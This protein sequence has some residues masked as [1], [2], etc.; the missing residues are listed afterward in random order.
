MTRPEQEAGNMSKRRLLT[1]AVW[2]SAA[3]LAAAGASSA[4][5]KS[6]G[7]KSAGG[8]AGETGE[9]A[10]KAEGNP[11]P[12]PRWGELTDENEAE[13]LAWLKKHR[14]DRHQALVE[15]RTADPRACAR[16]LRWWW[17]AYNRH[18]H[19]PEEVLAPALRLYEW[20]V[21]LDK[22]VRRLR[23][24][25][26]AERP[27]LV[28]ELRQLIASQ[29]DDEHVYNKY[30]V[31]RLEKRIAQLRVE[32]KRQ[33]EQREE[34]I[35]ERVERYLEEATKPPP[36]KPAR[37]TSSSSAKPAARRRAPTTRPAK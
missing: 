27:P 7:G 29:L 3:A 5:K 13:L 12:R 20:R 10:R 36:E 4:S 24:A 23:E 22:A 16:A 25:K 31:G 17:R 21:K 26:P 18:R 8:K 28:K 19:L 11:R 9:K 34:V 2:V 37:P 33:V 6:S 15:M 32:L 14:S 35:Q 1:V 30:R